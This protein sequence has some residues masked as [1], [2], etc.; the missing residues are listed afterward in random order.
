LFA[1]FVVALLALERAGECELGDGCLKSGDAG[2]LLFWCW[3]EING[4]G[5]NAPG[6]VAR[7]LDDRKMPRK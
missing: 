5:D 6:T 2:G 4:N 3:L 7:V 1:I